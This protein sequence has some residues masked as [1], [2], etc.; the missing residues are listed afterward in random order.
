MNSA[1][2]QASYSSS[3]VR[4]GAPVKSTKLPRGSV[5]T[6]RQLLLRMVSPDAMMVR[7]PD[8]ARWK[9]QYI[10]ECAATKQGCMGQRLAMP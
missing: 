5:V 6:A 10:D 2:A 4:Q 1:S 3:N 9:R 8:A 7:H